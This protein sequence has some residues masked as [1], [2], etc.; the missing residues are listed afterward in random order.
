MEFL[1][2]RPSPRV[3]GRYN[4]GYLPHVRAQ[5]RSYFVTFRLVDTLPQEVLRQH[6]TEREELLAKARSSWRYGDITPEDRQRL[7]T[8]FSDRIESCHD[9]GRGEC[10][11]RQAPIGKLV[12]NALRFL[13]GERYE[14]GPW[15]VMPNHVH[16]ITRPLGE[17]R[18]D[19]IVKSWKGFTAREANR[20]LNRT[21]QVFWAREYYDHVGRS[22]GERVR[23]A[24][25][26]QDNPVKAGLCPRWEDWPWS[27]AYRT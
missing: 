26:I 16:L 18:Q 3:T 14:L 6:L 1:D 10:W 17:H 11:L 25:Y 20:P 7:F 8:L 22:D 12:S 5:G 4:R 2:P 21:G 19:E 13:H 24:D 27:S 23:L 15:V 9:V